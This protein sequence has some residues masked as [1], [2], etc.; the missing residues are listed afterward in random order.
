MVSWRSNL[1]KNP[2][3]NPQQLPVSSSKEK[4]QHYRASAYAFIKRGGTSSR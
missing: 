3:G 2:E 4:K 1:P